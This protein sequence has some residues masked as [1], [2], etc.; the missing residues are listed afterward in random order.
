ME[1][2]HLQ[3]RRALRAYHCHGCNREFREMVNLNDLQSVRCPNCQSDFFE[4]KKS[5][6]Q[7][8]SQEQ[9]HQPEPQQ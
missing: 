7:A 6:E 1:A 9:G 4:E 5:F 3:I 8:A 2:S